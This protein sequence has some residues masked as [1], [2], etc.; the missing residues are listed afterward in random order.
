[1]TMLTYNTQMRPLRLPEYGRNIQSMVDYCVTIP[2]REERT[3]CAYSI[4]DSMANLF[5]ELRSGDEFD[6]KLWDHLMIM[7]DF[8]LD[9]DFPCEVINEENLYSLPE[10]V[11]YDNNQFRFRHYG[12]NIEDMIQVAAAM[13]PSPEKDNL[14]FLIAN[15]M[16]KMMMNF[17]LE[18]VDDIRIFNDMRQL[19]H[20]AINLTPDDMRLKEYVEPPKP[21]GKKK[22]KK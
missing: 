14:L 18:G 12:K 7:S 21:T 8:K 16:K 11:P 1:M 2:D 6:H 20:G 4:I 3:V 19:S 17:N 22:K 13:E 9:I 10:P 15:H 5:P